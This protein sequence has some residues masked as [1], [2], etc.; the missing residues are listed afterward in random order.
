MDDSLKL[1]DRNV[2]THAGT[3]S[4]EDALQKAEI[5]YEKHR[6]QQLEQP[7]QADKDF[8][9]AVK[10]LPKPHPGQTKAGTL[11]TANTNTL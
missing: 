3:I 5:E 1:S 4:H 8:E 10:S 11:N 2:L 9:E 7:S 6:A